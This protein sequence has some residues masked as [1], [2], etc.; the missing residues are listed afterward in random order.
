MQG[1]R[2][3]RRGLEALGGVDF[4]AA[5]DDFLQEGGN[6]LADFAR[7]NGVAPEPRLERLLRTRQAEGA[8]AGRQMIKQHAQ[9][10]DVGARVG[11]VLAHL[12]GRNIGRRS[13]RQP[14]FGLQ[15]IGHFTMARETKVDKTRLARVANHDV[16]GLDVV[17]DDLLL[18]QLDQGGRHFN[19]N[20]RDLHRRQRRALERGIERIALHEFHR[21]IGPAG[22]IADAVD[23]GHMNARQARQDHHLHLEAHDHGGVFA[24]L[25]LRYFE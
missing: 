11:A 20:R 10:K 2:Q 17:V 9:R 16:G 12:L 22:V 24:V 1:E 7:R 23:L 5:Q 21:D 6:I 18:V 15:Q 19:A 8:L 25:N 14:E 3:P 4:E 13:H